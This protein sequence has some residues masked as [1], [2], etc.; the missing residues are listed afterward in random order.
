[1]VNKPPSPMENHSHSSMHSLPL[2][3]NSER[4]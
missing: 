2:E 3:I 1:L 4:D